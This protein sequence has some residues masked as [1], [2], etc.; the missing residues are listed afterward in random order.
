MSIRHDPALPKPKVY[1]ERHFSGG[2]IVLHRNY[3]NDA[4]EWKN[5]KKAI[6][7]LKF[8][9]QATHSEHVSKRDGVHTSRGEVI[10]SYRY[11]ATAWGVSESTAYEWIQSWIAERR[12]ER[13]TERCSERNAERFFVLEY[14]QYQGI[15]ER[16]VEQ[17]TEGKSKRKMEQIQKGSYKNDHNN[18]GSQARVDKSLPD[19]NLFIHTQKK[20]K[21][22][23]EHL[24]TVATKNL[25]KRKVF[26][27][28]GFDCYINLRQTYT[29]DE[30]VDA[31]ELSGENGEWKIEN[32]SHHP[33]TWWL[34]S[35]DYIEEL[36]SLAGYRDTQED[37]FVRNEG[38][39][40]NGSMPTGVFADIFKRPPSI[41]DAASSA[42]RDAT[43]SKP[44]LQAPTPLSDASGDSSLQSLA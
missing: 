39:E 9:A 5:P 41:V 32:I 27:Q 7:W 33:M 31:F 35:E 3:L 36:L 1:N 13:Q 34:R 37:S 38:T 44:Q 2:Y 8:V 43:E 14:Q 21:K 28:A 42:S 17:D 22:E 15:A 10:G 40:K 12:I 6:A 29:A 18:N 20:L 24:L 16:T 19:G 11:F 26:T 4:K 23:F 25:Y 30:L